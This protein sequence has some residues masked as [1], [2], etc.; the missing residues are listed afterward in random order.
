MSNIQIEETSEKPKCPYCEKELSVIQKISHGIIERH[1]VY[2]CP[3]C[4]KVLSVGFNN[5]T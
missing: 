2:I 5:W 3:H 1:A 4:K